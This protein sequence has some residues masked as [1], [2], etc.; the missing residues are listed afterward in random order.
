MVQT[1]WKDFD[2]IRIQQPDA[3][4]W[5]ELKKKFYMK[6]IYKSIKFSKEKF[7]FAN[8]L[9]IFCSVEKS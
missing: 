9:E 4:T 7:F 6:K 8:M 1:S 2:Q 5:A 3:C